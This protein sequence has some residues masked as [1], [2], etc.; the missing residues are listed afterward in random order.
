MI[1][2]TVVHS[3]SIDMLLDIR[4]GAKEV[5]RTEIPDR[6]LIGVYNPKDVEC[7]SPDEII[8]ASIDAPIGRESLQSFLDGGEDIVFLINDGTRPTPTAKILDVLSTMMDLRKARYLVATGTHRGLIEE[9][10]DMIFGKHY[11]DIKDRIIE[12]DARGSEF[13]D[14]GRTKY[15][16]PIKFN[17]IVVDA[18]RLIVITS[19]EPHYF[20]GYS[21]GRKSILPGVASFETIEANHSLAMRKEA[22][23][24]VL[25]GNPVHEDMVDG[26]RVIDKGKIF[27]IQAVMDRHKNVYR[28]FSGDIEDAFTEATGCA[29]GLFQV[30]IPEKADFVIT[31]A[32]YPMDGTLYEAHNAM[33]N[34]KWA[35][36]DGGKILL[37]ARC[38]EGI[39]NPAFFK[40]LSSSKD[41]RQ[42]LDAISTKYRLGNHKAARIAEL[43]TRADIWIV[44]DLDREMMSSVNF[45][46]FPSVGDAVDL[47][48]SENPDARVIVFTHGS[49]TIP[50][51][52]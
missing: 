23:T 39:G 44:T 15:G 43:A 22:R 24:L 16:T 42:V 1:Y 37:V 10:F 52:V 40:M 11:R 28:V 2:G 20:A 32:P 48:L 21:G 30:P 33:D 8:R 34:G 18:D 51:V 3:L 49:V 4:Y 41:P 27:S 12:H 29:E 25:E 9:E 26:L 13:V 38:E 14:F 47:V 46:P 19:I 36:K 35:L 31:V 17:K 6:N 50:K 7:G 45:T 5:Q